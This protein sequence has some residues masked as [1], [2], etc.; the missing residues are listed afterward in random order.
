[1]YQSNETGRDEVYA[2]TFPT[3]TTRWQV[4]T[5]GGQW[6]TWRSDGKEIFFTTHDQI[7]AVDAAIGSGLTLGT[8][9]ALF[10]RPVINWASRWADGF[11]VTNDGQRFVMMRNVQSQDSLQPSIVVVQNWFEEFVD[12]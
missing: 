3:P 7:W 6:P 11:D 1:L 5:E 9:R 2:T 10:Q 4:S 8:P 12:R